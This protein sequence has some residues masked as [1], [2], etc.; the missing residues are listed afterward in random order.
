[1]AHLDRAVG[2][3][4]ERLEARH[5]LA[6]GEDLDLELV[7]GRLGDRFGEDL[8]GAV[9]RIE[10]FRKARGQP[11]LDFRHRLGDGR[12][13]D[14]RGGKPGAGSLQEFTTLHAIILPWCMRLA[15]AGVQRPGR[16]ASCRMAEKAAEIQPFQPRWRMRIMKLS[17]LYSATCHQRYWS[18]RKATT[19]SWIFLK[20]AL[21]AEISA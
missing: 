7:V 2:D 1:M 8:G 12:R 14:R 6:G 16:D 11:P 10:R 19:L 9:D 3:R 15:R 4:I 17:K 20:S 5:D 21:V 13:G 18:P